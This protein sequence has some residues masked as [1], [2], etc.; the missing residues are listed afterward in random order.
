[1]SDI[2]SQ[3]LNAFDALAPADQREVAVALLRRTLDSAAGEIPDE[4]LVYAADLL[5]QELDAEES[6]AAE[7]SYGDAEAR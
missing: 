6:N 3:L 7:E 2:A 5:F 4:G 1:M